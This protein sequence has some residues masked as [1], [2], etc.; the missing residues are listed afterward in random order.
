MIGVLFLCLVCTVA[1]LP[2]LLLRYVPFA[3]KVELRQKKRLLALYGAALLLNFA[4]CLGVSLTVG[5]G[6]AFCKF[7]LLGFW[8]LTACVN[9]LVMRGKAWEHLFTFGLVSIILILLLSVSVYLWR[10]LPAMPL[11]MAIGVVQ[12]LFLVLWAAL[13]PLLKRILRHIVTPFFEEYDSADYRRDLWFVPVA[14]TLACFTALPLDQE[15]A[16]LRQLISRLMI[17]VATI[18]VCRET[19]YDY[20]KMRERIA[21]S[22][23]LHLQKQYYS[24]LSDNVA[25]AR[26]ARHDLKHHTAVL[27]GLLE[28]DK[29]DKLKDY[30]TALQGNGR[31]TEN[32]PYTGNAAADGV[33]YHYMVRGREEGIRFHVDCAFSEVDIPDVPFCSLLGN[34]LDNSLT[35]CLTVPREERFIQVRAKTEPGLLLITI[36]NSFDGI[37]EK[38]GDV[39]LS[40]KQKNEPGIGIS[41]MQAICREY[42]GT[43]RFEGNGSIFEA[44]FL[45]PGRRRETTA[46]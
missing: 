36:D 4:V 15:I 46:T 31:L 27:S 11:P 14:M 23:Q 44:S 41:S 30:L 22:H 6:V 29:L 12:G 28:Q 20:T 7:N 37:L 5:M 45:F 2:G 32:I 9:A 16:N 3:A 39:L 25:E 13:H 10:F 38:R 18:F 34:A 8:I 33:L 24:A 35:A 40:R 17:G 42:N 26:R 19:A 1:Q 21:L 43:C